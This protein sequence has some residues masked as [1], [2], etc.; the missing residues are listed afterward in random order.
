M[1]N[2]FEKHFEKGIKNRLASLFK[3]FVYED[4]AQSLIDL[5]IDPSNAVESLFDEI[6]TNEYDELHEG[7]YDDEFYDEDEGIE[8]RDLERIGNKVLDEMSEWG[9]DQ[10][11]ELVGKEYCDKLEKQMQD[12]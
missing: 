11:C 1:G 7:R 8:H 9:Y 6:V 4:D 3:E 10:I 2:Y 5:D 12:L